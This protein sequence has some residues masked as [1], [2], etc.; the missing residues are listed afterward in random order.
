MPENNLNRRDFKGKD[1]TGADFSDADIRGAD[2]SNAVLVNT[3]FRN[4]KAGL[5]TSWIT[6]L[7]SLSIFT[8]L[9]SGLVSGYA[10]VLIV[11]LFNKNSYN[12]YFFGL[13]SLITLIVVSIVILRR[14]LGIILETIAE[15]IAVCI[16]AIAFFPIE[17]HGE[18]LTINALFT[19]LSLPGIMAS[20]INMAL[21]VALSKIIAIPGTKTTTGVISFIGILF[22]IILGLK[23]D[24]NEFAYLP[25]GLIGLLTIAFGAYIGSQAINGNKKYQLIRSLTVGIVAYGGTSFRGANL[26]DADFTQTTLTSVDFRQANLTRTCWFQS[27]NLEQARLEDTY[28]EQ[29]NI[30]QLAITKDGREQEFNNLNLRYLNLENAN[31]QDA[32][33]IS[34]DLSEANLQ[35]T[36]LFGAKLAQTQ[37]YQA[38]LTGACLTGAY[39]ENWGISTDTQLDGIECDYVYMRVPS[40]SNPDPWRKPDN[41]QETFKSGDFADFIAPIIKTLDLYKTQNF[42]PRKIG[43]KY[44][45]L[46]LL[47]YEGIDPTAAA[48]AIIQLA[49]SYPEANL[50]IVALEG[51]G[52]DKI[53]LQARVASDANASDLN[54]EYFQYYSEFQSLSYSNLQEILIEI[55]QKNEFIS[56][57]QQLLKQAINQ[58]KFYVETIQTQGGLTMS[59]E[60]KG[61]IN[62]SG[63]QGNISGV[64]ATGENSSM[65]GVAMGAI[66]GN[67]TNTINQLPDSNEPD[68]PGIKEIL[69]NLQTA[70]EADT[71]IGEEDKVEALEQVKKI[72]EAGQKPTSGGMQKIARNA[73]TFLKGLIVDLPSTAELVKTCGNLIPVIKQF[74]GLP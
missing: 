72:A 50:E 39:I 49:E 33:F 63:A 27:K 57:L 22:G 6:G 42:D 71:N 4:S 32:S 15:I 74:F 70:I 24:S 38:N 7:I 14:G 3:N 5:P 2:F 62:I 55:E 65:T 40:D 59:E 31:L 30:R 54:Q 60:N 16:A 51:R 13:F 23:G 45:T 52:N 41:R 34:T 68:K 73:L 56:Y 58:P 36:N 11:N 20:V 1:F 48:I 61:N 46:D 43:S 8:A 26:T 21:A 25:A 12:F 28:L 9:F 18:Y 64:N 47:H 19:A 44:K 69:S 35:N 67:V 17:S 29:P 10:G 53:R 37:L 66:S